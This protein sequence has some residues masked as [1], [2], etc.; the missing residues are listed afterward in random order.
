MYKPHTLHSSGLCLTYSS[1]AQTSREFDHLSRNTMAEID[2]A[3]IDLLD[4]FS[5]DDVDPSNQTPAAVAT[6][7]T[8]TSTS[9]SK[10]ASRNSNYLEDSNPRPPR[11]APTADFAEAYSGLG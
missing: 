11:K 2:L 10:S 1:V 7:S 9:N 6:Q 8:S 3:D 5:N 4:F